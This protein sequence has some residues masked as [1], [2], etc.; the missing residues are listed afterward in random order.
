MSVY[1]DGLDLGGLSPIRCWMRWRENHSDLEAGS[2]PRWS[3]TDDQI[4]SAKRIWHRLHSVN[5]S[6]ELRAKV[7]ASTAADKARSPSV[8]VDLQDEP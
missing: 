7:A 8:V 2:A 5:R 1:T 4:T 3:M 6:T